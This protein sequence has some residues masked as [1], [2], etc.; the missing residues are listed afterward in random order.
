MTGTLVLVSLQTRVPI[1]KEQTQEELPRLDYM[2]IASRLGGNLYGVELA[3]KNW[4]RWIKPLEKQVKLDFVLGFSAVHNMTN[5][6]T[7]LSAS[8]KVAIPVG[9]LMSARGKKSRHVVIGH[10]LSTGGKSILF[11]QFRIQD[12]FSEIITLCSAQRDY[13]INEMGMA[14]D[15][16]HFIF[17]KVDEIFFQPMKVDEGD[18]ILSVGQEQRDYDT[19]L[20]AIEGTNYRLIVVASSPWSSN[21]T[22]IN[23]HGM[24]EVKQNIPYSELRRL[25]AGARMVVVPLN[26]VDYA[27]GANGVLEAMS[28]AKPIIV[29]RTRGIREYINDGETGRFVQ[30]GDSMELRET[31]GELWEQAGVRAEMG[32]AARKVVLERHRMDNYVQQIVDIVRGV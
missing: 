7:I 9:L 1:K 27:A 22:A 18:Y 30:P 26:D 29:S 13:A 2:E 14:S 21:R 24:V 16:V 19:L 8:E 3:R 31:I 28:M 15:R 5:G 23:G 6:D 12:R 20:R 17:D 10:K 32:D 25:Y 4:Y 11:K